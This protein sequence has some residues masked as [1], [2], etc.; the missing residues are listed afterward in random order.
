MTPDDDPDPI[1]LLWLT[2][3]EDFDAD[4]VIAEILNEDEWEDPVPQYEDLVRQWP[5]CPE[6]WVPRSPCRGHPSAGRLRR[7][8]D[9]RGDWSPDQQQH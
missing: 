2:R 1:D 6:L 3:G 7:Q 4:Q 9:G 5:T 8:A